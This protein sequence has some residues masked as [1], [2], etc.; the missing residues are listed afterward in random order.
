M[1][2]GVGK[3]KKE[4]VEKVSNE[5][6][7]SKDIFY[8]I[9][10][11][12]LVVVIMILLFFSPKN[13]G[14][15]NI[16]ICKPSS[17]VSDNGKDTNSDGIGIPRQGSEVIVSYN[18]TIFVGDG[19][20]LS[21]E[22]GPQ[23]IPQN[24][25]ELCNETSQSCWA[26][27]DCCSDCCSYAGNG[28]FKCVSASE[29]NDNSCHSLSGTCLI[30]SDCCTGLTCQSGTCQ[31]P[32]CVPETQTCTNSSQCC[33]G[34]SCVGSLCKKPCANI[35]ETCV[36]N[37]DCCY[38]FICQSGLCQPNYNCAVTGLSCLNSSACCSLNCTNYMC[39]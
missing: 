38:G 10:I 3:N 32:L 5:S 9:I 4:D 7:F 20:T 33:S 18:N 29:C 15:S 12:A 39:R 13:Y 8:K 19:C 17:D 37:S 14:T 1:Q 28:L 22:C 23:V 16:S 26:N 30:N 36:S 35:S 24:C 2:S 31:P 6:F 27:S 34:L 11:L 25:T 21:Y